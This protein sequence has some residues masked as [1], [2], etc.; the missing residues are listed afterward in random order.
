MVVN[1]PVGG[2]PGTCGAHAV[3]PLVT[4]AVLGRLSSEGQA[5]DRSCTAMTA[6]V[7]FRANPSG[8]HTSPK[9]SSNS[10]SVSELGRVGDRHVTGTITRKEFNT[11]TLLTESPYRFII[12]FALILLPNVYRSLT[13]EN[14]SLS[15]AFVALG[16]ALAIAAVVGLDHLRARRRIRAT[17]SSSD[18]THVARGLVSGA[19]PLQSRRYRSVGLYA[20]NHGVVVISERAGRRE[21]HRVDRLDL[22]ATP[23]GRVIGC[24]FMIDGT[25][26]AFRAIRGR[27][28]SA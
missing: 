15:V 25:Q 8:L 28:E 12:G 5:A 3:F 23:A 16:L 7:P 18:A 2:Q 22:T 14:S 6:S 4:P 19:G 26:Y 24:A 10:F 17:E 27:I 11:R 9:R 13:E 20:T 1:L 21:E